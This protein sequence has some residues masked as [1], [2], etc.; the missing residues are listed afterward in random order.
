LT[1]ISI[2]L[3]KSSGCLSICVKSIALRMSPVPVKCW[4]SFGISTRRSCAPLSPLLL[5]KS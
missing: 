3:G 5:A 1:A 4:L 2:A